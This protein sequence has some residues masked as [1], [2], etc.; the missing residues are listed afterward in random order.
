MLHE[1]KYG[2]PLLT[3]DDLYLFNEGSHFALYEKLG[4]HIEAVDGE[5]GVSFAVWAPNA[6]KVSVV[7]DF[8]GWT[9]GSHPLR[10]TG[11]S[12]IWEGFCA[13]LGAG[14]LYKYHIQSRHHS[15]KVDKTD[16]FSFHCE[17]PPRTA[18]IVWETGYA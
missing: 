1:M 16:P 14:S 13:G 17:T 8:N 5:T 2:H 18:S 3:A 11:S 7:G 15:Y 10:Q 12:G 4:A 6:A 9:P